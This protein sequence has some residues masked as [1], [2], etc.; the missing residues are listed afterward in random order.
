MIEIQ[1]SLRLI[2]TP[3][4]NIFGAYYSAQMMRFTRDGA[5]FPEGTILTQTDRVRVKILFFMHTLKCGTHSD[6]RR[7]IEPRIEYIRQASFK[8]GTLALF[9]FIIE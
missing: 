9:F 8:H 3:H 2:F 7:H 5:L 6:Q 1:C 4:G